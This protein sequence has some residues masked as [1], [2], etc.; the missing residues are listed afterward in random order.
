MM[1]Y[2]SDLSQITTEGPPALLEAKRITWA[3]GLPIYQCD[4]SVAEYGPR[5]ARGI[6]EPYPIIVAGKPYAKGVGTGTPFVFTYRLDR[7][8]RRFTVTVGVDGQEDAPESWEFVVYRDQ[9]EAGRWKV[10]A[11]R[12]VSIGVDIAG[13]EELVLV[14]IGR[15][16][17][18]VDL[19]DACL[20]VDTRGSSTNVARPGSRRAMLELDDR[21][22]IDCEVLLLARSAKKI[23]ARTGPDQSIGGLGGYGRI[24]AGRGADT[25]AALQHQGDRLRWQ[26]CVRRPGRYTVHARVV[27]AAPG[28]PPDPAD[29]VV[30]INGAVVKC[31]LAV[32]TIVE[33]MPAERFTGHAWGYLVASVDLAWGLHDVE[34]ANG[35]GNFL[36][37]N[38]VI[39]V[40]KAS[41]PLLAV[42]VPPS[43]APPGT[44]VAP[45]S[46][47]RPHHTA[48]A[49][50]VCADDGAPFETARAKGMMFAP[51]LVG[52][53]D[54]AFN[55]DPDMVET[56]LE[57]G[58]PFSIH[59]RF[60]ETSM[61]DQGASDPP[62]PPAL[63][64]RIA[65]ELGDR[66]LG[67]SST[68]WSDCFVLWAAQRPG[69]TTRAEGYE[70]ARRWYRERAATRYD[71][72]LP[73]CATWH[74]D[75]YAGEWGGVAG[76]MDEPGVAPE[77]QL[78]IL[79]ARG[80][81]RQYG[82]PWH[83]YVAPGA[84]DA[85]TWV[86]NYYMTRQ[87][88][89]HTCRT[90]TAG[91]SIAWYRRM[92]YLTYM[93]GTSSIKNES[94]AYLT[95]MTDDGSTVLSPMGSAA[96]EFLEFAATHPDRGIC[97]T[98]VGLV[99]DRMHGWGGHPILPDQCPQLTWG[100]VPLDAGDYMKD[101]VFQV[102][103]PY[104]F[105]THNEWH[106]LSS[107]PYGDLFDIMLSTARPEHF[108]A[109][110]VLM[111][112]GDLAVDMDTDL[113]ARLQG[114]VKDGGTLVITAG[115]LGSCFPEEMIG[116][117][118]TD[119][120]ARHDTACWAGG[121][122]SIH[123]GVFRHRI[124]ES[125][126]AE[127]VLAT[128]DGDPLVT[129]H[130]HGNGR[131]LLVTVPHLLQ[132]N[133][134]GVG[135]LPH[136]MAYLTAGLIPFRVDGD[137]EYVVN[138]TDDA[139]LLTVLNNRGIY[140]LPTE[141]AIVDQRQR[142]R[143]RVHVDHAV[144]RVTD[145]MDDHPITCHVDG[146]GHAFD[147]DVAPGDLRIVKIEDHATHMPRR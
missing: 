75:H 146:G 54:D 113:V 44:L 109:Y 40:P 57:S 58:L 87:A 110:A 121:G 132:E 56:M 119:R 27:A 88:P 105:D 94:P 63:N 84:H 51:H 102:I 32:E 77:V 130:D 124:I 147:I 42:T 95:D 15:D 11:D 73:M 16:K 45:S 141:P 47:W 144:G 35:K 76:F 72:I 108:R 8:Y 71:N 67:Y 6:R 89:H 120:T 116:V 62:I 143:V 23:D 7:K 139:W 106:L 111:A 20:E 137:V 78:N 79:F 25:W 33:R 49:H 96:A 1:I 114:Y 123:G 92:L 24:A 112:V 22:I 117:R 85:H 90:P 107:S 83:S 118:I 99:L 122:E 53:G 128:A 93:W 37:T 125:H 69:I 133:L 60:T 21:L 66:F 145:W 100:T 74:Y 70:R 115:Q 14:G 101:A 19:A 86:A 4:R 17:M 68:E 82:K 104:Q 64:Q 134:N 29:Y 61:D 126:G 26:A 5:I 65:R 46:R 48:G 138:R 59:S 127:A 135:F 30:R 91:S 10:D 80:A 38:R 103:Y 97:C 43:A 142:Q 3:Y 50:Y 9:V 34:I 31:T 28:V 13:S 12:A 129:Q 39:L 81:A 52:V 36:A 41:T 98:P 18:M 131:V 55:A 136:L 2:L 140:K